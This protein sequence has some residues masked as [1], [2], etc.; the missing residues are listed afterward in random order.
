MTAPYC[1]SGTAA[2]QL[3]EA[4]TMSTATVTKEQWLAFAGRLIALAYAIFGEARIDVTE[5]LFGEPKILSL[6]LL[7]RTMGNFKGVIALTKETL[8]VEARTL[9]RSCY[10]N[11][12]CMA[13]LIE[14]G[15]DFVKAMHLDQMRSFRSQGE[16]LLEGVDSEHIGD[17]EFVGKI[18]KRIKEL[19]SR[20]PKANFL[21]PKQ[22]AKNS[23]LKE[24]YL[25]YSKLSSDAAHPSILALKRHL[26]RFE[27]N[28][29]QIL[30]L[31]VSP[32]EQGTELWDTVDLACNAMLGAC[33]AANQILGHLPAINSDLQKLF[34][35]YGQLSGSLKGNA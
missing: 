1:C 8:V 26:V 21:N 24:S 14:Q 28:G 19:K 18:R 15:D 5:K 4:E 16:F 22:T 12:Y 6:A 29:E 30:G 2:G 31:D 33:V 20:W 9:T 32:P 17:A 23:A 3:W 27:E 25:L 35:E 11:L 13:A 10:E 7:C 34:C